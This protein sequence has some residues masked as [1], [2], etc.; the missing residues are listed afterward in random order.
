M[1]L[2]FPRSEAS[3]KYSALRKTRPL[4]SKLH[5]AIASGRLL[6][7]AHCSRFLMAECRNVKRAEN[8]DCQS[9]SERE[10]YPIWEL[11]IGE[12][13]MSKLGISTGQDPL[14]TKRMFIQSRH[15][16]FSAWPIRF[17]LFERLGTTRISEVRLP[18]VKAPT[19]PERGSL[20][21]IETSHF[22][23]SV[24]SLNASRVLHGKG[25][26]A[27]RFARFETLLRPGHSRPKHC[28]GETYADHFFTALRCTN[29]GFLLGFACVASGKSCKVGSPCC[30]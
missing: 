11:V 14:A 19:V 24:A 13:K 4:S 1:T 6:I 29:S 18:L 7:L 22:N 9:H 12:T 3:F 23:K 2:P 26:N 21:L 8:A 28:L 20:G 16:S 30:E 10:A 5:R 27:V 17:G 25:R 15:A